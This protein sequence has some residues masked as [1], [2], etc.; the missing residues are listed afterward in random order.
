MADTTSFETSATGWRRGYLAL[1]RQLVLAMAV[2]SGLGVMVMMA[3]T[4]FDIIWRIL[5]STHL[6]AT[7]LI[8]AYDIVQLAG[9][10]T[11]SCALPYTTAVKGHVAIEFFFLKMKRVGR[12]IVDTVTRLMT[13]TL[14]ALL[15]WRC[16]IYGQTLYEN[17]SVTMTLQIPT[18]WV[19]YVI[20][21]SCAVVVLVIFEHL[22][23]PGKEMIKP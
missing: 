5:V 10:I 3:V 21:F 18:F 17:G 13:M 7:P 22:L 20:A 2:V 6:V 11:I 12:A 23:H 4:C 9:A 19:M 15:T 1:L 16:V 14:F 8:G